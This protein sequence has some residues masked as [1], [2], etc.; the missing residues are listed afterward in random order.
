MSFHVH[1]KDLLG[2]VGT[3]KTKSGS[4]TTPHMFPVLDPYHQILAPAFYEKVGIGAVMT[5]AYL[6]K[7]GQRSTQATDVHATIGF[8]GSVATDSGAYQILQYGEVRVKPGEIIDY[9][10]RINTDIGVILDVPTGFRS[11][12][13]RA[14]WTV[15]ETLR[16][17]D[18]ALD[19]VT[20]QDILWTGPVQ[21]G[22]HVHE[23]ERSAEEMSRREFAIY[24][25]G[26]PTELME[27]QRYDVLVEMIIAAKKALP[28]SKPFHLFGAGHPVL[29]P[30]LV[31]LG[32]DLFDSAAY[33]LYARAGRYLTSEGTLLLGDIHEFACSCPAC[34][35]TSPVEI[36]SADPREREERLAQHNLWACFSEL[37]RIREAIR[38]GRLWELLETRARAHPSLMDC[39]ERIRKHSELLEASTPVVK[40]RGIFHLSVSSEARP[41]AT[42]YKSRVSRSTEERGKIVLAL[43][44]RW[45]RPFHEDPRYQVVS[46]TFDDCPIVSICYYSPSW[47]PVPIELDEAF[48]IAQTEGRD[49]GD[50]ELYKSKAEDVAKFVKSLRPKSVI[51]VSEGAFGQQVST[52]LI[53]TVG[54][55][56]LAVLDGEKLKPQSIIRS[57]NRKVARKA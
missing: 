33:A 14:K 29:F 42:V 40:P 41:E 20:R 47:G 12:L 23:V 8:D 50:P 17:A 30:F 54:Q 39:F 43:P 53:K 56:K 46:N 26:S 24:A 5:N 10:E 1:S 6:L 22:V 49:L 55:R 51:L 4:F 16:R 3:L 36:F 13:K 28:A 38:K 31:A 52:Q 2:R 15:D 7:R 44:G 37:R 9:Q 35:G 34:V 18:E 32:C 45:R 57:V 27:S 48:P 19:S 11:D 21:G 25:L